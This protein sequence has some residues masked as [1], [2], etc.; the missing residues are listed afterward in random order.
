MWALAAP[1]ARAEPDLH[2]AADT[3]LAQLDAFRRDDYDAAYA[4]AAETIRQIFDR[5]SFE[6]MVRTGYPEIAHARSS[7]V[8]RA[9][10]GP[11]GHAYLILKIQGDNGRRIEAI[12]ELVRDDTRWKIASVVTRPDDLTI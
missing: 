8:S 6:R 11:D 7:A 1:P 2:A 12:Y 4:F 5:Q 3:V 9:A 10:L